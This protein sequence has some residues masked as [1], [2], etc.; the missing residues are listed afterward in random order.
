MKC[1][2]CSCNSYQTAFFLTS[3]QPTR[4]NHC[5]INT[6]KQLRCTYYLCSNT[7]KWFLLPT[8]WNP[9][10]WPWAWPAPKGSSIT[11][12]HNSSHTNL[13][14]WPTW[15]AP[16]SFPLWY[17]SPS[18]LLLS[19]SPSYFFLFTCPFLLSF[20]AY[21]KCSIPLNLSLGEYHLRFRR[22]LLQ[23][24]PV[25]LAIYLLKTFS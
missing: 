17:I 16:H 11:F 12:H 15:S 4:Y 5:E 8:R 19:L 25:L 21:L 9:K 13:H 2:F 1:L 10:S 22:H 18:M 20:Y 6:S 3:L 7:S 14:P 24:L 23:H